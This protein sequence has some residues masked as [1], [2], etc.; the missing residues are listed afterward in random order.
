MN[1]GGFILH[2][3]KYFLIR[4]NLTNGVFPTK[5]VIS[6]AISMKLFFK[7]QN[8]ISYIHNNCI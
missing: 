1:I 5:E 3:E 4:F 6:F 7:M 8:K 2:F